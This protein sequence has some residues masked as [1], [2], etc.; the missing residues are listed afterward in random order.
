MYDNL[1]LIHP[2]KQE[3]LIED[4][5]QRFGISNVKRVQIGKIDAL[6]S[7]ARL[8]IEFR[9]LEDKNFNDE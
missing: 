2:H 5:N 1:E 6:K 8:R 9:D 4:L 3:E 7:S